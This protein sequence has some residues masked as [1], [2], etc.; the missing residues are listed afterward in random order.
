[1]LLNLNDYDYRRICS[2][3]V[4]KLLKDKRFDEIIE[5]PTQSIVIKW[6]REV[7][8]L[9]IFLEPYYDFDAL[10]IAF[11]AF[12]QNVADV[13]NFMDGRKTLAY[14]FNAEK[15]YNLAIKYCLEHLI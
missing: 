8:G 14:H 2:F 3:E 9:H 15:A 7:H 6:L 10:Y 12:V 4:A 5:I 1:M 11:I 13:H